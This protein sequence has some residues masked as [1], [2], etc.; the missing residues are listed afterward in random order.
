MFGCMS[1]NAMKKED[2]TELLDFVNYW[3]DLKKLDGFVGQQYRYWI[4][5]EP[6]K[7]KPRWCVIRDV[8]HWVD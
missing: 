7:L 1:I 4:L 5:G 8:L 3:L 2:S 6:S